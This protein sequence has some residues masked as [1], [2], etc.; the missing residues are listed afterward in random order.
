MS[1]R[2]RQAWFLGIAS[3]RTS[4]AGVAPDDILKTS[5]E[6]L[7]DRLAVYEGGHRARLVEALANDY[8]ALQRVLGEAAFA[9]LT[10]RYERRFPSTS[11]DL[12]RLGRHLARFLE[13]DPLTRDLP[14][15]PDLAR[16]EWALAEAFVAA[17]EAPVTWAALAALGPD[18]V[19]DRVLRLKAG[20]A[21]VRSAWPVSEIWRLRD[22]TDAEVDLAVEGRPEAVVI[23]REGLELRIRAVSESEARL[24]AA[25]AEGVRLSDLATEDAAAPALVAAFRALVSAG[26]FVDVGAERGEA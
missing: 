11:H 23:H 10:V 18:A 12:G 15:L 2:E 25:A 22:R 4:A 14:F 21:L 8:P 1:L 19:A 17:D 7:A 20:T 13:A 26:I 9:S 16:L 24:L 3:G 6:L 5:G